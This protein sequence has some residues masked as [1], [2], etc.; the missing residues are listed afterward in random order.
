MTKPEAARKQM[1]RAIEQI[2]RRKKLIIC[3]VCR[4][5]KPFRFMS[6]INPRICIACYTD[7]DMDRFR[8]VKMLKTGKGPEDDRTKK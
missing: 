3:D 6:K 4:E 8:P 7:N 1:R 2:L 5:E